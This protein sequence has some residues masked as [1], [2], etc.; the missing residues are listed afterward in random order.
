MMRVF[1]YCTLLLMLLTGC[2]TSGLGELSGPADWRAAYQAPLSDDA[3]TSLSE[4]PSLHTALGLA[5]ERNPGVAA[6]RRQWLAA[7]HG[8]PQAT[9]LPD[10]MLQAGYQFDSVETRVGP[11][12]WSLGLSQ[13]LPW[14][15]KLW[16]RGRRAALAA[17]VA[18][19]RYET[20]ARNLIIGVKDAYYE[21]Y[22]LDQ[23]LPVTERIEQLLRNEGLLAYSELESGRTQLSEAFRA[24]SQAAQLAYDR[25]L[26]S[27]QRAAQAERLRS[28]LNLPPGTAIG[29]IRRAPVYEVA[30]DIEALHERAETW[31]EVLKIRGLEAEQAAYNTYLARLA[32]V[33][34]ITVGG[35]FIS[36]DDARGS[37]EPSD[38]DKDAFIGLISMNLPIWEQRNRALVREKEALE[39]AM[40]LKALDELNAVRQSVAQAYFQVK[41]TE[42]LIELYEQTLLPQAE[43][44]L[45]QT[46]AWFRSDQASFASVLETTL[47]FHNFTLARHRAIADHGQAIGR[48]ERAI[49]AIAGN[50]QEGGRP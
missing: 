20:A 41:L 9:S 17:D 50:R 19:L 30:D 32:R 6:A 25:L 27:E 16:A 11:Q 36:V 13:Q 48:L 42:R 10:P 2:A 5:M 31:A 3:A 28:L 21:L 8:Q 23:A 39:E 37:M 35:N 26:L 29:P 1:L 12:R 33:P 22:Y 18:R 7:I 38:S 47:A 34:D 44:A 49:G 4:G 24:E 15:Q 43:G 45:R 46:E 14:W 40:R